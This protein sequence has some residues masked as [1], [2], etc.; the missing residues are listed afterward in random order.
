MEVEGEVEVAAA[1]VVEGDCRIFRPTF[2]PGGTINKGA[3]LNVSL[4]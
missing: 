4:T 2:K 3:L 1:V